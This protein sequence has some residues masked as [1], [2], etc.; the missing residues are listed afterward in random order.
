L[1]HDNLR[2]G[3]SADRPV[4]FEIGGTQQSANSGRDFVDI[5]YDPISHTF[6]RSGLQGCISQPP[7][8]AAWL[9]LYS[10]YATGADVDPNDALFAEQT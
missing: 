6:G 10:L 5:G 9:Y 7:A 1:T 3:D 2:A 4:R 8:V